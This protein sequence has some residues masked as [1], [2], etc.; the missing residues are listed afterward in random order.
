MS[1]LSD[2][3]SFR[4]AWRRMKAGFSPAFHSNLHRTQTPSPQPAPPGRGGKPRCALAWQFRRVGYAARSHEALSDADF[5]V[6]RNPPVA[7][8]CSDD[9]YRFA[10]PI[11]PV[12]ITPP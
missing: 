5:C 1:N 10:P 11:L 2:E 9:G 12:H 3:R 6:P 7:K 8:V 4:D